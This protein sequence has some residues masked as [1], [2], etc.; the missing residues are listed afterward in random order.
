MCIVYQIISDM[1]YVGVKI[2][3]A[4][5]QSAQFAGAHTREQKIRKLKGGRT[6]Q[7]IKEHHLADQRNA[8]YLKIYFDFVENNK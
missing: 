1:N 5:L 4:P 7:Y 6:Y 8:G 3:I 2:H